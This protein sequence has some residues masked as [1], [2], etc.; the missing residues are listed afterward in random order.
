MIEKRSLSETLCIHIHNADVF[1]VKGV[2]VGFSEGEVSSFL[3]DDNR[4]TWA[5]TYTWLKVTKQS[6]KNIAQPWS[7]T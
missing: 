3:T 5:G 2:E 1:M 6:I 7:H 4:K